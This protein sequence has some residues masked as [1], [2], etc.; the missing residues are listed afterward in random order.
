MLA[1]R[2]I[3][4]RTVKEKRGNTLRNYSCG[5]NSK[6]VSRQFSLNWQE[7]NNDGYAEKNTQPD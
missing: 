6:Q 3:E 7:D 4:I 2:N 5:L 1:A